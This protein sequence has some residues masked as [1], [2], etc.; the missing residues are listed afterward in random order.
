MFDLAVAQDNAPRHHRARRTRDEANVRGRGDAGQRLAPEAERS[1]VP[2][3]LL[4]LELAGSVPLKGDAQLLGRDPDAIINHA[5]EGD[6]ALPSFNRDLA[7]L[8]VERILDELFDDGS[9]PLDDFAR[10]DAGGLLR[11]EHPNGQGGH[12]LRAHCSTGRPIEGGQWPL[13]PLV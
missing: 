9:G 11:A 12:D 7:G 10:G 1:D 2:E 8:G 13:E 5:Q 6:A 3:L 4:R